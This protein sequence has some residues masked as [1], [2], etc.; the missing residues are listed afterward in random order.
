MPD[1]GA[2]R[3]LVLAA[4]EFGPVT[5]CARL[6]HFLGHV[7][8]VQKALSHDAIPAPSLRSSIT[9]RP[10]S[11]VETVN[12]LALDHVGAAPTGCVENCAPTALA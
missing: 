5:G 1:A 9:Y 4:R 8:A 7:L 2:V 3:H 11:N 6:G 10:L 12:N